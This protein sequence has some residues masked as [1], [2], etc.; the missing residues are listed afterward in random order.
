MFLSLFSG[1]KHYAKDNTVYFSSDR[2]DC[3]YRNNTVY[4]SSDQS[5]SFYRTNKIFQGLFWI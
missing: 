2:S 4:L 1:S 3:F 5:D